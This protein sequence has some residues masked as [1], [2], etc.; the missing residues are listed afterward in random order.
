ME[1]PGEVRGLKIFVLYRHGQQDSGLIWEESV[2]QK[3]ASQR[4]QVLTAAICDG[5]LTD[6][7]YLCRCN[8]MKDFEMGMFAWII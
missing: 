7:K 2:G 8:Y 5:Y 1:W 3:T 4:Y 6:K